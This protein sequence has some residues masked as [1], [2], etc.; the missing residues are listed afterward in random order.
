MLLLVAWLCQWY[1]LFHPDLPLCISFHLL[2]LYAHPWICGDTFYFCLEQDNL[3]NDPNYTVA[4]SL[5]FSMIPAF[6][7]WPSALCPFMYPHPWI[8]SDLFLFCLEQGNCF[9]D[10]NDVIVGILGFSM[11]PTF[12]LDL[13]L[14][15]PVYLPTLCTNPWIC[16]DTFHFCLEKGNLLND[17]DD[18]VVGSVGFSMIF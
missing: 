3:L 12:Y 11:I 2:S 1:P 18:T 4:G 10:N 7:P 9:N 6:S 13:L 8:C 5:G 16:G 15:A 17:P 14:C